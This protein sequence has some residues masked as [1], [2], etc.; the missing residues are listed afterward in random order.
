MHNLFITQYFDWGRPE[1]SAKIRLV[2]RFLAKLGASSHLSPLWTTNVEQRMNMFHLL[3]QVLVY[4]VPG[5]IVELGCNA[6]QSAVLMQKVIQSYDPTRELHVYDSFEGLPALS[7]ADQGTSANFKKGSLK[8]TRDRLDENFRRYNLPLPTVHVGWFHE[9]LP[10]ELPDEI[11]FAHL[12]ADL[13]D[14]TMV[15]LKHTYPRLSKGAVCLIDDYCDPVVHNGWNE[16]PGVKRA[17]DEFL[18]DRLER[19]SVLYAGSFSHGFFRKG[20]ALD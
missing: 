8:T 16:L 11:A 6:G 12:D 15:S 14:S 20:R 1:T 2:N 7:R 4:D 18:A 17:C 9:T 10:T 5:A 3:S 19:V 13:Y